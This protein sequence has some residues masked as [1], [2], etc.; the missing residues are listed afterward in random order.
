MFW[1][2][3]LRLPGSSPSSFRREQITW[4]RS[5]TSRSSRSTRRR[6]RSYRPRC[7]TS[8]RTA[9]DTI[10]WLRFRRLSTVVSAGTLSG[11]ILSE[12]FACDFCVRFT[13]ILLKSVET[14][15][16]MQWTWDFCLRPTAERPNNYLSCSSS[17]CSGHLVNLFLGCSYGLN[18]ATDLGPARALLSLKLW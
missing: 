16:R 7:R 11:A 6:R 4:R 8:F 5:T 14:F 9:S 1:S 12:M 2:S 17:S 13:S 15:T 3:D 18:L 10:S